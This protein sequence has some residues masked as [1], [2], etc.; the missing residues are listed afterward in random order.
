MAEELDKPLLDPKNFN[1]EGIDLERLPWEEVFEQLRTSR[2]GLSSED[3]EVRLQI[4]GQNKL[5]EKPE[6]NFLKFLSFMWNP[7]S[8]VMEAA[9]VMAIVLAN[10]GVLRD[11]QW[12]EQDAAILVPGDIISIK[13]GDI[14]PADDMYYQDAHCCIGLGYAFLCSINDVKVANTVDQRA[15]NV[16]AGIFETEDIWAGLAFIVGGGSGGIDIIRQFT[17]PKSAINVI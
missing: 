16:V 11:G 7:L 2:N 9:A 5:E 8:W 12:Q 17:F 6:N 1:L 14:I 10:G 4:F 15:R 3:A 13:L